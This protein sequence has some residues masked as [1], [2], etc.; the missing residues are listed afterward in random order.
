MAAVPRGRIFV[1][2]ASYRDRECQWTIKDLF[3]RA[4]RPAD[5]TVGVCWQYDPRADRD[6]FRIRTRP[7]QVREVHL[8]VHQ[9]RGLGWARHLTECLWQ[10][11]DFILQIDAHMRFAQDWDRLLFEELAACDSPLPMISQYP[12]GYRPP[13]VLQHRGPLTMQPFRFTDTGMLLF[14]SKPFE[15]PLTAPARHACFAGGFA[16]ARADAWRQIP[17]DPW[18]YFADTEAS[19]AAR[20][21]THGWDMF[22]PT[23]N[24]IY[25]LYGAHTRDKPSPWRDDEGWVARARLGQERV[26]HVLGVTAATDPAALRD[27]EKYGLGSHRTLAEYERFA[28]VDFAARTIVAGPVAN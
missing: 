22:S 18:L 11:E 28:G 8:H 9:A 7:A 4:S 20:L 1:A 2:I 6:C 12:L 14:G 27:V 19:H 10:G 5:L 13:R 3:A 21:W 24:L 23:R 17:Q 16:F 15:T 26:H 25:H